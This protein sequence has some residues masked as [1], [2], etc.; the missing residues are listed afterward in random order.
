MVWGPL[1]LFGLGAGLWAMAGVV[2]ALTNLG[3]RMAL[4]GGGEGRVLWSVSTVD[5]LAHGP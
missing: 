4:S 3:L 2:A 1:A 5:S